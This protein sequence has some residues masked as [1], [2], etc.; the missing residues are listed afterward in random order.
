MKGLSSHYIA[1][2]VTVYK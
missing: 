1:F 2:T